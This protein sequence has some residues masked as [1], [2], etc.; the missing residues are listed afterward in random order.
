MEITRDDVLIAGGMPQKSKAIQDAEFNQVLLDWT[1]GADV[2]PPELP[3]K[4]M[5]C[6]ILWTPC[7]PA[8]IGRDRA[9]STR[10]IPGWEP[11]SPNERRTGPCSAGHPLM[12]GLIF[13][14]K[15]DAGSTSMKKGH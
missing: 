11:P 7:M 1:T 14:E 4:G 9:R 10:P 3:S 5:T 12:A 13:G 15:S 8:R 6:S 2:C